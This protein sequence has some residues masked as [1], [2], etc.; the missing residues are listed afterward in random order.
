MDPPNEEKLQNQAQQIS[1][2][3]IFDKFSSFQEN[4]S[5]SKMRVIGSI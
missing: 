3:S 5:K 2:K 4:K 1:Y